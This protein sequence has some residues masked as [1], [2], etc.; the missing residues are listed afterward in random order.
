M[1]LPKLKSDLLKRMD[2]RNGINDSEAKYKI[3]SGIFLLCLWKHEMTR[4]ST[5]K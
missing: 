2:G 3:K 5:D 4:V 1:K